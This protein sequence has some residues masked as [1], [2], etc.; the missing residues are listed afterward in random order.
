MERAR[1]ADAERNREAI[2]EAGIRLLAGDSRASMAEIAAAAGVSRVTMY[3][4]FASRKDLVGAV[5]SRVMDESRTTLEGV[6]LSG[7]EMAA[8]E[9]L[10]L[11][12]WRIVGPG[13]VLLAAAREELGADGVRDR[14]EDAARRLETLVR[15][16]RASGAFRTDV[17]T[18]W[19]VTCYQ[20]T[21]HTAADE[22]LAGRLAERSADRIVLATIRSLFAAPASSGS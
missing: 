20:A 22:L 7:D 9:R 4:H 5:F 15:R 6:D 19:L 1:R 12:S 10:V 16:G 8:L 3:G 11:A 13:R 17:P 14:H 2:V 18:A 21:L